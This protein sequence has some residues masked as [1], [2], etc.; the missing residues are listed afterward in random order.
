MLKWDVSMVAQV[1]VTLL[2][3]EAVN[4][5]VQG[6]ANMDAKV[7]N[8]LA[9]DLVPTPAAEPA[10]VRQLADSH[11][12]PHKYRNICAEDANGMNYEQSRLSYPT[13]IL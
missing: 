9:P 2:A 11:Y 7:V 12:P 5:H 1:D 8:T 13:R 4:P 6:V 10:K 3:M